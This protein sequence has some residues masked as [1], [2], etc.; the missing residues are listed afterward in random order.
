MTVWLISGWIHFLI[1]FGVGW[2]LFKRPQW[3]T[4]WFDKLLGRI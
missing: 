4:D 2:L 3:V 1:G